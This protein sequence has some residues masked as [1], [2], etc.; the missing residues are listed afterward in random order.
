M[1]S[2]F[3]LFKSHTH[4][5]VSQSSTAGNPSSSVAAIIG[6]SEKASS[7]I[8]QTSVGVASQSEGVRSTTTSSDTA[9]PAKSAAV[10]AL[11]F[12]LEHLGKAPLPG[13]QV[14]ISALLNIISRIQVSQENIAWQENY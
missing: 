12:S 1:R 7:I 14:A 8:D 10:N 11:K 6:H 13:I 3:S 4:L 2:L 5:P 9:S